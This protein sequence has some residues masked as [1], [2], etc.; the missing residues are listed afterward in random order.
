MR[1]GRFVAYLRLIRPVNCLMMGFAVIIGSVIADPDGL[2]ALQS[3]IIYGFITGFML[4]GASM[5]LN[6][7]CDREIDIINEPSR[8]IPS[9]LI[10]PREASVFAL[11]LSIIGFATAYL[12]NTTYL[13]SLVVAII[14]W[15]LFGV[16]SIVGKRSGLA[17]NFLVSL[18]VAIPFIYGSVTVTNGV[19]MNTL[20][21]AS[22]VFFAN[23]GR[24]VTKGIVDV[25]GDK[26]KGVRTLAVHY[27][28]RK[29]VLAAAL[30]Y[31]FA[32]LMSPVPWLLKLVSPWYIPFVIM[33]DLGFAAA[34]FMLITNHSRENARKIKNM[35]LLLFIVGLFAFVIGVLG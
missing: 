34:S 25:V 27:G 5:T 4:T 31:L 30:F 20:V 3:N 26:A 28:E 22:I 24:E 29:A 33:T 1:M 16:Y 35:V 17:G 19:E 12:A 8:P 23:T 15:I 9:G 32:V 13:T 6:D 18:C 10:K 14:A 11:A 21:F 7:Y 2:M